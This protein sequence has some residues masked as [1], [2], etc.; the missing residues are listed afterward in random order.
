LGKKKK[1]PHLEHVKVGDSDTLESSEH[2][3]I[4]FQEGIF[5]FTIRPL[6]SEE[7]ESRTS[8]KAIHLKAKQK[9]YLD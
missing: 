1:K 7:I 4:E 3:L 5:Y 8:R 6:L 9:L 2:T